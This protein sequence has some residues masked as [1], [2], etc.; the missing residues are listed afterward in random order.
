MTRKRITVI[1]AAIFYISAVGAQDYARHRVYINYGAGYANSMY[2][3]VN[4]SFI[5]NNYTLNQA[6]EIKYAC[7]F[8]PKWGVGL[9][10]GISQYTAKNALNIAGV[11]PR[12]NDPAYDPTGQRYYDLRYKTDNLTEQQRIW[13]LET[14][15]QF[16]FEHRTANGKRGIL[17]S[18]GAKGYFPVLKAQSTYRQSDGTLTISGYDAFTNT[19]YSDP[20][21]FGKQ[22]VPATPATVKL[23]YSVDA[24]ADFGGLFRLSNFCNLYIGVYG[25]YS[26][27]DILP[28]TADKK[29]FITPE[30]NNLYT[31][32]ALPATNFLGEYNNY[33]QDNHLSWNKT[34]E[35]WNRWQIC[36]KIGIHF[37]M[38]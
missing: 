9:G 12:Y 16:Y 19:L 28:K 29:D 26:F 35:K 2:H 20:P 30:H 22:N 1:L 18:L 4:Q 14:P 5:Y 24:I 15:V 36:I 31:V 13:A 27:M 21:H 38:K 17:A 6:M 8:A 7:F 32:N 34:D 33:I 10:A 3:K 37:K 25:S 11:I 23:R